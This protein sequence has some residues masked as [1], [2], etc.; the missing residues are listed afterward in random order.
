MEYV[1]ALIPPL[2]VASYQYDDWV[3]DVDV[4]SS[5][6]QAGKWS[7]GSSNVPSGQEKILTAGYDGVLTV[8][9]AS[10]KIRA[11]SGAWTEGG[12]ES[13]VRSVKWLSSSQ[14]VSGGQDCIVRTWKY[15]QEDLL[16]PGSFVPQLHLWGHKRSV[17]KVAVHGPSNRILSASKDCRI[18]LWSSS[19]SSC[20]DAPSDLLA[21]ARGHRKK[22]RKPNP[23]ISVPQKGPLAMMEKHQDAA[24][25]VAFD[26]KDHTVGYSTSWDHTLLTWDLVTSKAVSARTLSASLTCLAQVPDLSLIAAG[27]VTRFIAMVDPREDATKISAMTLVG[28]DNW[29][30]CLARDPDSTY[31]LVSGSHDGTCRIWDLR[32]TQ[33]GKNGAV[34]KPLYEIRRK[35]WEKK[36]LPEAGEGI[37][38]LGVCWD[39]E[40]GI[41]SCGED[42]TVQINKGQ[43]VGASV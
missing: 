9:D 35:G 30:S 7:E 43:S 31:G 5:T 29:I 26:A 10:S 33:Q 22:R 25:D 32:N 18:G 20:P 19:K 14:V 13:F 21:A 27:A 3:S 42:K 6:S 15:K 17:D 24:T 41:V 39:K 1:R 12:H 23:S 28:H 11:T 38:V 2:F 34:S 16:S 8:R 37:K 40:L 36:A 4:L